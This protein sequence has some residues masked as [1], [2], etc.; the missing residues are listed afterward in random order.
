MLGNAHGHD[1]S[2]IL[3]CPPQACAEGALFYNQL[4]KFEL[5]TQSIRQHM[6]P[7]AKAVFGI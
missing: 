5:L 6:L 7:T 1:Q 4:I 3:L 2:V